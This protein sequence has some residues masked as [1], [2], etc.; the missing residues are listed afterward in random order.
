MKNKTECIYCGSRSYGTTCLFSPNKVHVHTGDP[1]SCMYCGSKSVGSGCLFNPYN[2]NHI[3]SPEYL[4][5]FSEQA[6]HAVL[7]KYIVE[8]LK[9]K[10]DLEYSSPLDRFYKGISSFI[11]NI[12]QPLLEAFFIAEKPTYKDLDKDQL[13]I[14]IESKN[15]LIDKMSEIKEI[16]SEINLVLP[17]EIVEEIIV[18]AIISSNDK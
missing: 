6:E 10:N 14:V 13:K 17:T 4:N 15:I 1:M 9:I 8:K 12:S 2:K 3:R 16:L 5:R 11:S 18:D 7:L